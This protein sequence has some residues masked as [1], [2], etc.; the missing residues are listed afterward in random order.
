LVK[1]GGFL[2]AEI[3]GLAGFGWVLIDIEHGADS[4][5]NVL[6]QLQALESTTTTCRYIRVESADHTRIS[7][8]L[9]NFP[10]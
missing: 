10:I 1:S 5:K 6:S 3:V 4:E 7:R 9:D 2:T 8:V